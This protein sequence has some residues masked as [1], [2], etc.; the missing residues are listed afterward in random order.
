VTGNVATQIALPVVP[1]YNLPF[2]AA[3][4]PCSLWTIRW[5]LRRYKSEHIQV[6]RRDARARIHRML[7]GEDIIKIRKR[8]LR[9]PDVDKTCV[10]HLVYAQP[11]SE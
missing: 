5:H 9:G 6:Y 4:V 3:L 7:R 1:L 2:A 8:M 10:E 11:S